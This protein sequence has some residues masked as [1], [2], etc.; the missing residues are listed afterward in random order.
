MKIAVSYLSSNN[1]LDCIKK[2]NESNADFIH[3]DLCDGKYVNTKNFEIKDTIKLLKNS[4]KPLNIHLMVANPKKIIKY[5]KNLNVE[6]ITIHNLSNSEKILNYIKKKG[7]KCGIALNPNENID[8]I[9]DYLNLIDELLIMSVVPGKGGQSFINNTLEK[10]DNINSIKNSYHFITAIDGGINNE[11]IKL[12]K[13]KNID[14]V[15]S[16]SYITNSKDYNE[17][18]NKLKKI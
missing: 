2:I 9:K 4:K 15:I 18:I 7:Y 8:L 16:G 12:L 6:S 14:L 11:T 3:V 5:F 13:D 10:I 17:T 1:Y